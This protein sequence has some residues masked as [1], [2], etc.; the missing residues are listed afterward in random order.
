MQVCDDTLSNAVKRLELQRKPPNIFN[1]DEAGLQTECGIEKIV[2]KKESENPMLVCCIGTGEFLPQHM[3]F[4]GL[5]LYSTWCQNGSENAIYNCSP[6]GWME[7][8][9]FLSGSNGFFINLYRHNSHITVPLIEIAL[10]NNIEL[11]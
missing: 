3:N 4:K 1:C 11:F 2:C 10:Q 9:H 5:H 7:A 6:C 8:D